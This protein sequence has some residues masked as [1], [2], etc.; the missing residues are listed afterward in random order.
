MTENNI[1][2]PIKNL[3]LLLKIIIPKTPETE[4]IINEIL[5]NPSHSCFTKSKKVKDAKIS[6]V[7]L[8][9][10]KYFLIIPV[11]LFTTIFI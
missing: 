1:G 2:I 7:Q 5:M 8:L 10:M 4:E 11:Y 9:T 6:N 3:D